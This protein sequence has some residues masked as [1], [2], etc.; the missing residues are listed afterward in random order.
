MVVLNNNDD[1]KQVETKRFAEMIKGATTG[2]DVL[3]GKSIT[4]A[5]S[6]EVPARSATIIEL[7]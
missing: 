4:L 3:A 2:T 6:I 5:G 7:R 1:A